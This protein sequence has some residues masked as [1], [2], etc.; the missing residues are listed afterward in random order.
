M[1]ILPRKHSPTPLMLCVSG[2]D[3]RRKLF[4]ED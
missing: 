2:Q 1:T 4:D 3:L